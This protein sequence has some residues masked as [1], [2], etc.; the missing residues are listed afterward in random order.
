MDNDEPIESPLPEPFEQEKPKS[1]VIRKPDPEQPRSSKALVNEWQDKI[2][3]AKKHW[4]RSHKTIKQDMDFFMGKQWPYPTEHDERYVANIVQSHI[5][6]KVASLYAKN[7]KAT[8]KRR[9]T[10]DFAIWGEEASELQ[11]AQTQNQI[12]IQQTGAPDPQAMALLQDVSEGMMKRANI[13]KVARTLEIVFHHIMEEQDIKTQM[14]QLVRRTCVTGVGFVKLGY[15][16]M[17]EKRPEDAEKITDATEELKTLERLMADRQDD[18][19]DENS[20]RAEQLKLLLRELSEKEEH[21]V[22]EGLVFDFPQSQTIIVD[23][24]CRQIKGFIGA[25]WVAQE[26]ILNVDEVKE[27]YGV[28]LG[29]TYTRHEDQVKKLH[30]GNDKSDECNLARIW[31]IYNKRDGMKYVMA[32]GYP[33]FLE[34][35][36]CPEIKLKRFW[37]FFVLTFNE[38]ENEREIYP[39]SDVR[40]LMPIQREYNLARQRLREHRNANRPLYVTPVGSLS[41]SDVRKL[42]DRSPNEVIQLQAIQPGQKVS[43]VLQPVMPIPIDPSLYD[44]SMYMEDIYR[45][46]GSQEANMGGTSSSTATEVSV[47]E[48]S[49]Q[50]AMGSNVDDLDEFLSELSKAAGQ[51]LLTMMDPASVQKIA[52]PGASWPTLSA[53]EIADNLMLEI[54]A[55]SS[56][57]PNKAAEIANFERLAPTLLQIPGIDPAWMAKEA[58]KRM[59]DSID[60]TDVIKGALPSIVAQNAAKENNQ[61]Q[62]DQGNGPA[63]APEAPPQPAG[64]PMGGH[65]ASPE[66]MAGG[67]MTPSN[68]ELTP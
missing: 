67:Q 35:P 30:D 18:I 46:I 51:V 54:Q 13:E 7:P 34:E 1:G 17:M 65:Q 24:K 32:D 3:R 39:P 59:D 61:M 15:H 36:S 4:D 53:Q 8:A 31:E 64:H 5:K 37:P 16:R 12:T 62:A 52:G 29:K 26:F 68:G 63:P 42:I 19:F 25:D 33:E 20:A 66:E 50:T 27:I 38:V 44:V 45:V 22:S 21:I 14:K 28:D 11:M 56:G 47:A 49:R 6:Q 23:P 40:L 2:I 10:M 60:L 48:S 58:I 57:R 9:K 55:G 43:D 41:E